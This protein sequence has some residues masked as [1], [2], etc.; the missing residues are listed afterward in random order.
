[1]SINSISTS[2]L[3]VPEDEELIMNGGGA[4]GY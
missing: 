3:Y 2:K 4:A 1:M